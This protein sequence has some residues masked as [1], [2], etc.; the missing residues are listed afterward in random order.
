MIHFIKRLAM[1]IPL[2]L[3]ISLLAFA[4]V[5]LAPGGPFSGERSFANEQ[6]LKELEARYHLDKPVLV[7]YGYFLRDL[8]RGDLGMSMKY[9][10]HTVN[11]IVRQG[12]PVSMALGFSAFVFAMSTGI[13]LGVIT[14]WKKG[15]LTGDLLAL[16]ALLFICVPSMVLG[17]I[18]ILIFAVYIPLFPT[19]FF[20]TPWHAVLPVLTL[21]VYYSGKISRLVSEG[22]Q[23]ALASDFIRTA[24]AKGVSPILLLFRHALPMGILPVVSYSGPLL[25]DLLTGSFVVENLFQ[26]PGLGTFLV[27]SSLNRDHTMIVGLVLIY[28]TL[29]IFFNIVVDSLYAVLD[30]RI[31]SSR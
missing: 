14:A 10:N 28:S 15:D 24:R 31:R 5:R 16:L 25:A 29:I 21:G 2:M 26:I 12:L 19:S 30:P 17:P 27:N 6:I 1:M 23:D 4:L 3:V 11:D 8:L 7:Q 18:L 22:I 20:H 9:R 13:T